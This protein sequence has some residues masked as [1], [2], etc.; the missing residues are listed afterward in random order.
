MPARPVVARPATP[1]VWRVRH[2]DAIALVAFNAVLVIGMWVRHGGLQLLGSGSADLTAVGE[3]TALLG[4]Y[5]AL[6]QILL[7]SRTPWLERSFG[8]DRLAHWH[9][10]LGFSTVTLICAHVVF[11]TVGY[12]L[13][14]GKSVAAETW[15]LVTTYPY[16]LMATVATAL[17]LLVMVTSLRLAR[18]RLKYETWQFVHLYAYLAIALAFG[19]EL[20]VGSDF[21]SDGVARAYWAALYIVV[22]VVVIGF[23]IGVP[24]C[25]TL[26]HRLRVARVVPEAPGITSIYMTGRRLGELRARAGQYFIWRFLARDDW[27]RPHPFSLSASPNGQFLRITVKSVGDGTAD[28]HRLAPGTPVAL[29]GPY[30]VFT[31][32]LRRHPRVLLLAAGIGITPIRALLEEL[33]VGRNATTLI[34]RVR[35]PDEIIFKDELDHLARSRRVTL[36]VVVGRRGAPGA[37]DDPFTVRSLRQLVADVIHRDVF[38]CGPVSM[39]S[40]VSQTLG[41]LGVPKTQIHYERFALL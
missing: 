27:W 12:A 22:I 5:A 35:S 1:R 31:A 17:L 8:M 19:H 33:P 15:T 20:A 13:G 4:T 41:T 21:S 26:R 11:T 7:M 34:Y 25:L 28:M 37:P 2:S 36:H 39:M 10:W 16:M 23:R 18:R 3:L 30:G 38:I 6:V 24:V 14:D 29:E 40:E 9:R 32:L